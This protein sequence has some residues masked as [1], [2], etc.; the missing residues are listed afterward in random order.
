MED[1][2]SSSQVFISYARENKETAWKLAKALHEMGWTVWLDSRITVGKS[3]QDEIEQSLL[4]ASCVV[5]LWSNDSVASKWV[6][7]EAQVGKKRGILVPARI[8]EVELPWGFTQLHTA[9]LSTW[10]GSRKAAPFRELTEAVE[11]LSGSPDPE[12]TADEPLPF[13]RP[14]MVLLASASEGDRRLL[15]RTQFINFLN[16]LPRKRDLELW[17]DTANQHKAWPGVVQSAVDGADILVFVVS[18]DFIA[19]D[20]GQNQDALAAYEQVRDNGGIQVAFL[21]KDSPWELEDWLKAGDVVPSDGKPVFGRNQARHF[22]A[23]FQHLLERIDAGMPPR[24]PPK[25]PPPKPPP[26]TPSKPPLPE[27]SDILWSR[28]MVPVRALDKD[29]RHE[30][31]VEALVRAKRGVPD[32][33]LREKVVAAARRRIAELGVKHLSKPELEKLDEKFVLPT[34]KRRKKVDPE[35]VRWI[36]RSKGLHPQARAH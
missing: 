22:L 2:D 26:T 18:M 35:K 11:R 12:K 23:L 21:Y 31:K 24:T 5:V 6:K 33:E 9:D 27:N 32:K 36:L 29:E 19:S 1:S 7:A 20:F 25:K 15:D 13:N 30:L 14:R 17:W 16:H 34:E 10:K 28:R 3:F 4:R 8:D